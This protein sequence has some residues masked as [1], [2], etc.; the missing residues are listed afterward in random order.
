MCVGGV[1]V[2][3]GGKEEGGSSGVAERRGGGAADRR[4][5]WQVAFSLP[6]QL[7]S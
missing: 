3:G 1:G 2:G 5:E 6:Q 7:G 4:G